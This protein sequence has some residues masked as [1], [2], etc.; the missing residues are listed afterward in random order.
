[1]KFPITLEGGKPAEL[2]LSPAELGTAFPQLVLS[3]S[4]FNA[5]TLLKS[6]L[7]LPPDNICDLGFLSNHVNVIPFHTPSQDM[8]GT[9]YRPCLNTYKDMVV[10]GYTLPTYLLRYGGCRIYPDQITA[11][12]WWVQDTTAYIPA[13]IWWVQ[14][15]LLPR[16]PV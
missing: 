11:K 13:K 15:T 5:R 10:A 7:N 2:D 8:V 12:I 9:G 3:K 16:S 4:H 1:M 14:D 6:W